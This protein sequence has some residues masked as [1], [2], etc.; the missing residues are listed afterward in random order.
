M[1]NYELTFMNEYVHYNDFSETW[2]TSICHQLPAHS[3][4]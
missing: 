2:N 3:D 1:P 4:I